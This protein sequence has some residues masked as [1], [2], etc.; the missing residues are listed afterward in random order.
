LRGLN[1]LWGLGLS[2][3]K[4]VE[5]AAQLGSDVSVFLFGGAALVTGRG[6]IVTPLPPVSPE[7]VVLLLPQVPRMPGKTKRLYASLE[8]SHYT[9]GQIT[10]RLVAHMTGGGEVMPSML[11]NVFDDVARDSFTGL[12]EYRQQFLKAGAEEVHLA[13]SGPTLFTMMKDRVRAEKI[14]QR[15]QE[16]GLE[17]CLVETIS[18]I[19]SVSK[20]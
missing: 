12:E 1:K 5:L 17:S 13:G 19:D 8:A 3:D 14:Y 15:L 7:Q 10:D 6:E 20:S 11:F 2:R 16:Q 9:G 4:L 18:D